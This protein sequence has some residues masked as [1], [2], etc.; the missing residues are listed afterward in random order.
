V[1]EQRSDPLC[2]GDTALAVGDWPTAK[3]AY[4]VAVAEGDS[5]EAH[6]GLGRALWWMEGSSSAIVER[7]RAYAGFQNAGNATSAAHVALWLSNEYDL[8]VGNPAAADGWL[9]RADHLLEHL[10]E[11]SDHARSELV[12]SARSSD[13][14]LARQHARV[15]L[16]IGRRRDDVDLEVMALGRLGLAEVRVGAVES[17]MARLDEAMAAVL[18]GETSE[19]ETL[20]ELCCTLIAAC[21]LTGDL[22]RL[23]QWNQL[24]GE[25]THDRQELPVLSFCACCSAETLIASGRIDAA[26]HELS[27]GLRLA[28]QSNTRGRCVDPRSRL[29]ELL[30]RQGRFEEAEQLLPNAEGDGWTLRALAELH[31]ARGEA[32]AA[33]ITLERRLRQLGTESLLSVPILDLLVQ[34]RLLQGKPDPAAEAS[35]QLEELADSCGLVRA[36]AYARRASGRVAQARTPGSGLEPLEEALSLFL[37]EGMSLEAAR[38]RLDLANALQGVSKVAAIEQARSARAAFQQAQA[39]YE[40]DVATA[41][42]RELGDRSRQDVSSNV[43]QLTLRETEVLHLLG[44]GLSNAEIAGRLFISPKTASNHVSS[45]LLKLGLRNRSQAAAASQSYLAHERGPK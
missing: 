43:D 36:Q 9:A 21:D 16:E 37:R 3:A 42:L 30:V 41:L 7:T 15:A 13:V 31:I 45:I 39:T 11:S 23:E 18:G 32:D 34:A 2:A 44:A 28:Q 26:E 4:E 12:R 40:R 25:A 20:G 10:P 22:A 6:D 35:L 19:L 24:L 29:A 38:T 27:R 5:P 17:G 14:F 33:V 1:A 8:G